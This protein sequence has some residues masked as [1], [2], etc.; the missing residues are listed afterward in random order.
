MANQFQ[1]RVGARGYEVDLNGHVAGVVLLQYGQHARWEC[2]RAAGVD[3]SEFARSGI[4]TVSLEENICFHREL[5]AGDEVDIS[6]VFDW[7]HGKTF[8]V[9]QEL[10]RADGTLVAEIENV[11]GLLDLA[12]RRLLT[13]PDTHWRSAAAVP[14]LL[15]L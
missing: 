7:P 3:Y 1:V 13:D 15:G 2:L 12:T 8:R 4:G 14:E 11:G 5:K 10:R 6:C 9:R